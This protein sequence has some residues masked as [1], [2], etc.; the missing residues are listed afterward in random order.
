MAMEGFSRHH[1]YLLIFTQQVSILENALAV[2]SVITYN[3]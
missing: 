1:G 3:R 2:I